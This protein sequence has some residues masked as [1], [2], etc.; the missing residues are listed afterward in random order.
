M[1]ARI[2]QK[3]VVGVGGENANNV[4]K[5]SVIGIFHRGPIALQSGS[6]PEFLMI[7]IYLKISRRRTEV[8]V[9]GRG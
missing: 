8:W 9:Q 7:P 5:F 2:R 6:A 1:H 3:S 4:F